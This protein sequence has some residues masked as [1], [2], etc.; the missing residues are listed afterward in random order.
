M[1]IKIKEASL[2]H[3]ELI[4]D[5]QVKMARETENLTLDINIVR[6]GVRAVFDDDSKG[7]YFVA[8]HEEEPIASLLTTFEWSDWR[9]G[10]VWWIQSVYVLPTWRNK[11]VFR[12]MYDYLQN[13]IKEKSNVMGLRLYVDKTNTN[14]QKVYKTIGMEGE[15]YS[16]FEWM[17]N[18]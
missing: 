5:Y 2:E 16:L 4:A 15:H 11:K 12:K 10:T 6:K 7:R 17:K 3:Q 13:L 14:A 1:D 9:N 8:F 18:F